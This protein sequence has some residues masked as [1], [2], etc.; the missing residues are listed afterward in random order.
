MTSWPTNWVNWVTTGC[1]CIYDR[2]R[3]THASS[4]N[5][6]HFC[7]WTSHP[8]R[9]VTILLWCAIEVLLLT[10][11]LTYLLRSL[12]GD[13]C[14]RCERVDNSTSSWVELRRRSVVWRMMRLTLLPVPQAYGYGRINSS[15]LI[16]I[17]I[18]LNLNRVCLN[19][20]N[21]WIPQEARHPDQTTQLASYR[22]HC[23]LAMTI[24]KVADVRST[25]RVTDRTCRQCRWTSPLN[26]A[27]S[28]GWQ[29]T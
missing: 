29:A 22:R 12:I 4:A 19:T 25:E 14:S 24:V 18:I 15:F 1:R 10:Y 11:L 28:V 17:T 3:T 6:K 23:S 7:L 8:R 20:Q 16:I 2:T 9:I 5:W 26:G 21:T 27:P 13:S